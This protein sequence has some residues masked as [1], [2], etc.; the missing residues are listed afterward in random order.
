MYA[1]PIQLP[2]LPQFDIGCLY[3]AR[4]NYET[5]LDHFQTCLL[6]RRK[7]SGSH[8]DVANTLYEMASAYSQQG[9]VQLAAK[10]L[11]ESDEI[12]MTK[13]ASNKKLTMVLLLSGKLWKNLQCYQEA[14]QNFE[15]ALEKA[16]SVYGQEHNLVASILLSLGEFLQEINQFQQALFCFEE[17][18]KVRLS[19][20]GPSSPSLAEVEYSKG[21][22]LLFHREF[23]DAMDCLNHSLQIRQEQLGPMDS[24]VGDTLN[25]IGFLQLR[26]GN[27]SDRQ[28]LGP[29]EKALEIRQ[30]VGNKSKVVSTLQNIGIVYKKLKHFDKWVDTHA[31]IVAVRQDE[32]GQND[33]RVADAWIQLG[34]V[35]TRAGRLVQAKKSYEAALRLRTLQNGY[36]NRSVAQVLFKIGSLNSNQN[37]HTTAKQLLEEYMRIRAKEEDGPDEEMA[38]ALTLMG[39]LQKETKEKSKAQINWASA[40]EIYQQLGYQKTHVKV[41]K[42]RDRQ[43]TIRLSFANRRRYRP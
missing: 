39:D 21:V 11:T 10:C 35:Q 7:L 41:Q 40:A 26:K 24:T 2:L 27:I 9:N 13:L 8:V 15:L 36:D 19:L 1:S 20:Y 33:A 6:Q 3:V 4:C 38:Q 34:N 25:S 5:A 12:W 43:Q 30:S 37:N 14:E 32:F 31:K 17:C 22:A 28:A 16:T 29:L 18:I 42:L 23:D